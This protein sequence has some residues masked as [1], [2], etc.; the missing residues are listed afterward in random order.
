MCRQVCTGPG[1]DSLLLCHADMQFGSDKESRSVVTLTPLSREIAI[2][3]ATTLDIRSCIQSPQKKSSLLI[4]IPSAVIFSQSIDVGSYVGE[5]KCVVV[6]KLAKPLRAAERRHVREFASASVGH[7]LD[8]HAN[9]LMTAAT[10]AKQPT[11]LSALTA[12]KL[13][14]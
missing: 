5:C 3:T 2:G 13:E 10:G 4:A 9:I 1:I 11:C 14:R 7:C 12:P 8:A 6:R